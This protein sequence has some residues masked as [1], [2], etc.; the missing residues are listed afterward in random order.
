MKKS[1][2]KSLIY[3]EFYM[4]KKPM[5]LQT[6]TLLFFAVLGILIE[7]SFQMGN[8]ALLPDAVLKEIKGTADVSVI[9]YP[10]F[11]ACCFTYTMSDGSLKDEDVAWK[12]FSYTLPAG[13]INFA[14]AKFISF[15]ILMVF[16][17]IF[18]F[19]Y[20]ALACHF[21]GVAFSKLYVSYILIL[22]AFTTFMA[23]INHTGILLF[24]TRD[25]AGL[26]MTGILFALIFLA[27]F[28]NRNIL[29]IEFTGEGIEKAA[30]WLSPWMLGAIVV[31]WV[32]GFLISVMLLKRREK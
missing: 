23:V 9:I 28:L 30:V 20:V 27:V 22:I 11:A 8:L 2:V 29:K 18:S 21:I 19:A 32:L 16:E 6:I 5:L 15:L 10:V 24:H 13:A 31:I 3:K 12:R 26:F 4:A 1:A 7:I 14:L 25:K 17:S